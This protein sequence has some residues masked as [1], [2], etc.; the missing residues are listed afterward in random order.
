MLL[1]FLE[2]NLKISSVVNER[3]GANHFSNAFKIIF[4]K[5][6]VDFLLWLTNSSQYNVSFL[7]SK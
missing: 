1:S 7:I 6:K 4:N 5:I 2:I 3:I